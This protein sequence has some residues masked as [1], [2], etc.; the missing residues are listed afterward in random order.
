MSTKKNKKP[1]TIGE[2][3]KSRGDWGDISPVTRV[4]QNKKG[5][6]SYSRQKS[7]NIYSN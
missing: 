2:M 1:K 3:T 7:K 6:G 5:K 4:V